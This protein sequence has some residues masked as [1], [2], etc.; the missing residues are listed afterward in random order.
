[1][2][3]MGLVRYVETL[4]YGVRG[5]DPVMLLL[6]VFVLLGV[7]L[8]AAMPAVARAVRIDPAIML[9]AE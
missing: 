9:R 5:Y 8:L 1:V 6:P 3:G 2:L 4:L 7:A